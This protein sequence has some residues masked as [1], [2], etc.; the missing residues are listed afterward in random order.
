MLEQRVDDVQGVRLLLWCCAN[1]VIHNVQHGNG[2]KAIGRAS[3]SSDSQK[4][5]KSN[6]QFIDAHSML[7]EASGSIAWQLLHDGD[8]RQISRTYT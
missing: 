8:T 5:A 4:C 2:G 7:R 6:A 3:T 1:G